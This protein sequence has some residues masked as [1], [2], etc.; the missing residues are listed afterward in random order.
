MKNLITFVLTFFFVYAKAQNIQ[1][2]KDDDLKANGKVMFF[3][4]KDELISKMG[5]AEKWIETYPECGTYAEEAAN[6]TPFYTYQRQGFTFL[7]Y[8]K[9]AEFQKVDLKNNPK[10][11]IHIGKW[12]ISS[13]TTLN[14]LKK[15]FPIAYKNYTKEQNPAFIR[16]KFNA[17]WDDEIQIELK[18]HKVVAVYYWSP[19]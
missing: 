9:T 2:V 8:S 15:M 1:I 14:N 12:K 6:K 5:K 3:T 11:F 4:T 13:K 7:V 19:C 18:N 17:E 16:L 10:S